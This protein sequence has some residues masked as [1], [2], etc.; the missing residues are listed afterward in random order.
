LKDDYW[1]RLGLDRKRGAAFASAF[2]M[3]LMALVVAVAES[4]QMRSVSLLLGAV[5]AAGAGYV[6]MTAPRRIVRAAAFE[7]T[8]ES[9]AFAASANIYLKAT[10]S[11]SKTVV[12]LRAEERR[13]AEFL[14]DARRRVLLGYDAASATAGADPQSRVLAESAKGVVESVVGVDGS[15]V[16]EGSE[17]LDGLLGAG[18]LDEETKVPVFMAVCFFLPIMLM[19]FASMAKETGPA[20]VASL[21]FLE[22]IVLDLTMS[23]SQSSVA[24]SRQGKR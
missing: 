21:V 15:R 11:R 18:G 8:L 6:L 22:V 24:W 13:L 1:E 16:E 4:L 9:P 3:S 14:R 7:Q 20:A 19:L 2:A 23:V 10:G 5:A 12:M 17:E